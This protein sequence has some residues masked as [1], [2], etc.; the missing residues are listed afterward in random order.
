[1]ETPNNDDLKDYLRKSFDAEVA[2]IKG[3]FESI[4]INKDGYL[5]AFELTTVSE[6]LDKPMT[7][8]E[9]DQCVK[10][11]DANG[12]NQITFDEF[13]LWWIA[14]REGAPQGLGD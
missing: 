8:E 4:D 9:I 12:D 7:K 5:T 14:G 3:V 13:A 6:K 11:I 2:K 1:M 10:I